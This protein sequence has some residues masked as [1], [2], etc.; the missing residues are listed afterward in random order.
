MRLAWIYTLVG[1]ILASGPTSARADLIAYEGFNYPTGTNLNGQN[2]GSGFAGAWVPGGFNASIF[3]HLTIAPGSL[4]FDDLL[5]SGNHASAGATNAIAGLTR[6]LAQPLGTPG[7]TAY[8]SFLLRPE[9]ILGQGAF[10]GF[11]G[12]TLET[13]GGSEPQLFI[14]KPGAGDLNS[15]VLENRGGAGQVSSGAAAVVGET[16]VLVVKAEFL[17]GND[18]FTLYVNPTPGG[19]EPASGTVKADAN[20]GTI[21]G[22][23][24]YSTGAYSIDELRVGNTFADVT[25]VT[26]V[27]EPHSMLLLG[28]GLGCAVGYR[29][30]KRR[31]HAGLA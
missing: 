14:G 20:F 9:G 16:A 1:L 19:P 27:P 12:V 31:S 25:P 24:L 28:L 13:Q 6:H 22:L 30:R 8:L 11:F 3:N 26:A 23:T 10:N 17:A 5:T 29:W 18:R 15:Y 21:T 2:G 7:T 4:A